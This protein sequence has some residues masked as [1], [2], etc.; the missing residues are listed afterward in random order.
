M[1]SKD[2]SLKSNLLPELAFRKTF[3]IY[4]FTRLLSFGLL[5]KIQTKPNIEP[6]PTTKP[7]V[8][9]NFRLDPSLVP[10]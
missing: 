4:H 2:V 6:Q 8:S 1:C 3:I 10:L 5:K 7:L 9:E